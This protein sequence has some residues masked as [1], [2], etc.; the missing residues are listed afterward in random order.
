VK[1]EKVA[2]FLQ[3]TGLKD[4]ALL[5][6]IFRLTWPQLCTLITQCILGFTDVYVAGV[7]GTDVQASI[8]LITQCHVMLMIVCWST[9]SGAIASVS[10]SLGANRLARA[11]RYV[12]ATI[13]LILSAA[14][15]LTALGL[16]F[17]DAI[18]AFL[19]TPPS[20]MQAAGVFLF[21]VMWA[22]PGHYGMTV[23]TALLRATK[24]VMPPLYVGIIVCILNVLGDVGFGLGYWGL[25]ACG[26]AGIAW[27]TTFAATVGAVLLLGYLFLTGLWQPG[28]SL[29]WRWVK[30]GMRYLLGVS[31]PACGTSLLWNTGYLLIFMITAAL[32]EHSAGLRIESILFMPANAGNMTAAVLVGHA[33]GKRDLALAMRVALA[34]VVTLVTVMSSF[35]VI[36]W[37]FRDFFAALMSPDI[38][39]QRAIVSY[40]TYNILA[41][42]FTVGTV[43][44][45]GVF[46]GAGASVYPMRAFF[47]SIWCVRL[48]VAAVLGLWFWGYEGIFF[49]MLVSQMVQFS[50]VLWALLRCNWSRYS[51]RAVRKKR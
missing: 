49:S 22:L 31:L 46:N 25:P 34:T 37:F 13:I 44:L 23:A 16:V 1:G 35:G 9:D 36:F 30:V 20:M 18:L 4:R 21:A 19:G 10:Q 14:C 12:S 6:S 15:A 29:P 38:E 41:I 3:A 40:L 45:A 43:T 7:L 50:F 33:L 47:L 2:G 42:P 27:S 48:P 39:T 24:S 28:I 5:S 11:R 8:G 32:P 26:A 17:Q 51:M